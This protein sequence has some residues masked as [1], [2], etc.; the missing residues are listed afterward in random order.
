MSTTNRD[1]CREAIRRTLAQRAGGAPDAG[2][3]AE[4]TLSIW[5]K[6]VAQLVPV[7]GA[8]GVDV[9]FGRSLHLAS[10]AFPWLAIAGTHEDSV[11]LLAS[12]KARLADREPNDAAEA[13]YTLL[14]TFTDLLISLVGESLTA[15]LLEPVWVSTPPVSEKETKS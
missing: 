4:A 9:I 10:A 13:G 11:A 2:A 8:R 7:I 1:L 5:R 15:R 3:V 14:V 12:L 6:V